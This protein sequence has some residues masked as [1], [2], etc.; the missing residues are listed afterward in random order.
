M[1]T[2]KSKVVLWTVGVAFVAA[3]TGSF[4]WG[5]AILSMGITL[6]ALASI[7][8]IAKWLSL[9]P[10]DRSTFEPSPEMAERINR[11]KRVSSWLL[12]GCGGMICALLSFTA[13]SRI[14]WTNS[15]IPDLVIGIAGAALVLGFAFNFFAASLEFKEIR[16]KI[17]E[18]KSAQV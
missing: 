3:E 8:F 13:L 12:L 18:K 4:I 1:N 11:A 7:T 5:N 6:L 14:H 10:T 16:R 17:R 9:P 2:K 15:I